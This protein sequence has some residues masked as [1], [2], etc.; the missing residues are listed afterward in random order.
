M[1][2]ERPDVQLCFKKAGEL[3]IQLPT[4]IGLWTKQRNSRKKKSASLTTLKPLTVWITTNCGKFFRERGTPDH[5]T[6]LLRN[7][8][9]DHEATVRMN[10]FK[11]G[12]SV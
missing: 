1:N 4:F 10:W 3:E 9:V 6:C 2:Q 11:S 7:L 5:L 8:Y 12:K